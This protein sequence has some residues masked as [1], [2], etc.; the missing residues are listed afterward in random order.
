MK[1]TSFS[2]CY[3]SSVTAALLLALKVCNDRSLKSERN[4]LLV[5]STGFSAFND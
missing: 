3:V 4:G 1:V 2:V 5:N